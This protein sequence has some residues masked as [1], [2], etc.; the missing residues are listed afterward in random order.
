MA[1]RLAR[2]GI[3]AIALGGFIWIFCVLLLKDYDP[4][5]EK[6]AKPD[7]ISDQEAWIASALAGLV[8]GIVASAFGQSPANPAVPNPPDPSGKRS[9][10]TRKL[11]AA[12]QFMAPRESTDKPPP[13]P[14]TFDIREVFVVAYV[15]V[16]VAISV[17]SIAVYVGFGDKAPDTIRDLSVVSVGLMTATVSSFLRG[18]DEDDG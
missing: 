15:A 2:L 11:R 9:H 5:K 1:I 3:S 6:G 13:D 16:Y 14:N 17:W 8:G 12:S 18:T 10:L 4:P 7:V